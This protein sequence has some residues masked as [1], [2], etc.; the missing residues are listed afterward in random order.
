MLS[1]LCAILAYFVAGA[2]VVGAYSQA[3]ALNLSQTEQ[4]LYMPRHNMVYFGPY[5]SRRFQSFSNRSAYGG[6][7]GGGSGAG[8]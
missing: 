5:R 6:F 3:S 2:S 1:K 7:R 8:K 4:P